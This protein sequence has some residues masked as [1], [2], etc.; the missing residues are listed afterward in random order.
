MVDR[1]IRHA[2]WCV[3][4]KTWGKKGNYTFK[5]VKLAKTEGFDD[6][7]YKKGL[8]LYYEPRE[9]PDTA[10][11][12]PLAAKSSQQGNFGDKKPAR[13]PGS[14]KELLMAGNDQLGVFETQKA[15]VTESPGKPTM[16]EDRKSAGLAFG[17]PFPTRTISNPASLVF[18]KPKSTSAVAPLVFEKRSV[19]F[20]GIT[21]GGISG[22]SQSVSRSKDCDKTASGSK[23]ITF[24]LNE[25]QYRVK[26][27]SKAA[28]QQITASV[29]VQDTEYLEQVK[30][31]IKAIFDV[32]G[33]DDGSVAPI[34]L[35]LAWHCLATYDAVSG[36]GGSNGATMRFVPEMTDEGNTGLDVARAALEPVKQRFSR[37]SYSDLWTLGGKMAI[38]HMGGPVIPWKCGRYDC[39]DDRYVPPNGRLPFGYKG[40]HHIREVFGRM[41][42]ND[43]EA[44]VLCGAHGMGRCHKRY[45]GWEGKWTQQP[46]RFSNGL[47]RVLLDE[48]WDLGTVPE[49][50]KE[51][52]FNSD[53]SL[54][55]L[56]TDMELLRDPLF[57][58]WVEHY[59]ADEEAFSTDFAA[60]FAK[61]LELGIVRD[62]AGNV[63]PRGQFS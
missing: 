27:K 1:Y 33:Y 51:Q 8:N 21:S 25:R 34:V 10:S 2:P 17:K 20:P 54:M 26:V 9:H 42:F 6:Y 12:A 7:L 52:Y 41:G 55:M 63:V 11:D 13:E 16:K 14:A 46:T 37:I 3:F 32:P 43:R 4:D 28:K 57:R 61:L 60:T 38:E 19:S 36:N 18:E 50:G 53:K 47:F 39:K 59:G 29:L 49:T 56:N 48:K 58:Q 35:R 44:V 22:S 31:A 15:I 62:A 23:V 45:S 24:K 40:A 5:G 30:D